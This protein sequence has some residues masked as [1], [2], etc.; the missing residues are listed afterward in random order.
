MKSNIKILIVFLVFNCS[1][2]IQN[3]A[4]VGINTDGSNA[5]ASAM[6]DIKSTDKGVLL[7]RMTTVQRTNISSA[8]SVATGLLV[9]DTD[10]KSLVFFDGIRW[11]VIRSQLAD[12]DYDTRVWAE[13]TTDD[14][15]IQFDL[16]GSTRFKMGF[17]GTDKYRLAFEED[18]NIFIGEQTALN[19]RY[20]ERS[21][22]IGKNA[23]YDALAVQQ[24]QH[25]GTI[26]IGNNTLRD[27]ADDFSIIIGHEASSQSASSYGNNEQIIIG[28]QAGYNQA[29]G[30]RNNIIG[31]QAMGGSGSNGNDINAI[32]YQAGYHAL[33]ND[34]NLF[35]FQAGYNC[36]SS[37][38]DNNLFGHQAGYNITTGDYNL[39]FGYQSGY[40]MTSG[41]G[42]ILMGRMAG[43]SITDNDYNVIIGHEAGKNYNGEK[44]VFIG[45]QAGYNETNSNRLYIE[46]SSSSSPLIYG[47]F[48]NNYLQINGTLDIQGQYAFHSSGSSAGIMTTNGNGTATVSAVNTGQSINLNTG[49]NL[50][51]L[52]NGGSVS[53]ANYKQTLSLS[54]ANILS[55]SNGGNID[56][57]PFKQ[58]LTYSN[59]MLGLV[60][61]SPI[62]IPTA[63]DHLG[64]HTASQN[65]NTNG[66]WISNDGGN[67]GIFISTSGTVG[68][69]TNAPGGTS[70]YVSGSA[71]AN[72]GGL[73]SYGRLREANG[74]STSSTNS[75]TTSI[76]ALS[77]V[78]ASIIYAIS[79]ARTKNIIG[80]SDNQTDLETLLD[81]EVTDY[82]HID[83]LQNGRASQ[84]KVIAQ[85]VAK[86]FPQAVDTANTEA[87]PNIMKMATIENGWVSFNYELGTP[88]TRLDRVI[89]NYELKEGDKV[90]II[91]D[92]N[93]E[94]VEVLEVKENA[95][96]VKQPITN[97]SHEALPS[98]HQS[99]VTIF[100]Y[101][102]IVNN[103]HIVDYDALKTLNISATQALVKHNQ[104]LVRQQAALEAK[105]EVLKQQA[106]KLEE[107]E[108][109]ILKLK[110]ER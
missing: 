18:D 13:K 14:D 24:K 8:S 69:G 17:G 70:L 96:R 40:S 57:S 22:L 28:Y 99:P 44:S 47:E 103:F 39:I 77:G 15:L 66:H 110:V 36:N 74:C 95:F 16:N 7:P 105:V 80:L 46:N 85:Q 10:L 94:I 91:F 106:V 11:I 32:G 83:T 82:T 42:N 48:D 100:V 37:S 23:G 49:N 107:L 102:T 75:R 72:F 20:T 59:G 50:L 31:S 55:L 29:S 43:H 1:F 88:L 62:S 93:E 61:Q 27:K 86:I 109:R 68:I 53:L 33:G 2:L 97:S 6:M 78:S 51:S 45:Y 3:Y 60:G 92:E 89:T 90:K 65:I 87:I 64:N 84:K 34:H 67:E 56:L 54:G 26:A 30:T 58:T 63:A 41:R 108:A 25:E 9:Y 73:G 21:V 4:Q 38:N 98:N 71:S 19:S 81:I 5:D 101:G 79:D 12:I 104:Q 76:Y 35:G 52:S